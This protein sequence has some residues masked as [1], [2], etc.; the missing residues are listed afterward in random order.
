MINRR[1]GTV[2]ASRGC[3]LLEA[4]ELPQTGVPAEYGSLVNDP[5]S[6]QVELLTGREDGPVHLTIEVHDSPA[7]P[8]PRT[9]E[10]S[11][12]AIVRWERVT[13]ARIQQLDIT[14]DEEWEFELPAPHFVLEAHYQADE[15][16]EQWLLR[17]WPATTTT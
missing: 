10:E 9:W 15:D 12:T 13:R 5:G 8:S 6:G 11:V 14:M 2:E 4:E 16:H 1:A 3:F 7:P 17:L